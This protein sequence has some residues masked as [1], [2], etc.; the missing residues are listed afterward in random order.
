MAE[1][2]RD[3]GFGLYVHWPFCE[4]KCPYCD[5]NSHVVSHVDQTRW[6]AALVS[7]LARY[8]RQTEGRVLRSIYFG[9]GTP[10][11]MAPETV[12][13][14][15]DASRDHWAW[16]NDIEITLEANPRSVE[17]N[18]FEGFA[19]A[20][21]NRVSLGVQALRPDDLR[22][23]GRLHDVDDAVRALEIAKSTF[24]RVNFDLI[25]G[26]QG[27]SLSD[28]EVELREALDLA[29]DHL[30][31]YQ[32]T[33]EEGT[34]FWDRA[35]AGKL[36]DLPS[37]DLG[38]DL[39]LA[40]Q[41][42][43]EAAGKPAYEVSN[44]AGDGDESRHNLVYWRGGDYVGIGPGAH[45]RV[46]V[47]GQRNA[48]VARR[49]PGDWI[50]AAEAGSADLEVESLTP[51]DVWA[52]YLMMG[53]RLSEGLDL[54]R[55]RMIDPKRTAALSLDPLVELGLIWRNEARFGATQQGRMLLNTLTA[56]L[57]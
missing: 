46:T 28:W 41:E 34:A 43:C 54:E 45:G 20:G 32:L 56:E 35:Q 4:A 40:T 42:I 29:A 10:S 8:G 38:A 48:T 5:F 13:A 50:K 3:G 37:E 24:N 31:L 16:A 52:E 21:V 39:Y 49:A 25:Y 6:A 30:S 12:R 27:Q 53:L 44:H 19:M 1:T 47:N 22:R 23:L 2:W 17:I 18:K 7:E 55:A 14:V 51:Q 33:I 15:L 26:R 9:G 57:L 11:L 36:R